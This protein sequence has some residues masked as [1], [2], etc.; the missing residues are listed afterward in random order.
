[1]IIKSF[2]LING[3]ILLNKCGTESAVSQKFGSERVNAFRYQQ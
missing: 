2:E 3:F 1:M